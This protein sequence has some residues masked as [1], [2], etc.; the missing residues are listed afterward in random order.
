MQITYRSAVYINGNIEG[1]NL[2]KVLY[3]YILKITMK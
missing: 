3:M 2:I 1:V